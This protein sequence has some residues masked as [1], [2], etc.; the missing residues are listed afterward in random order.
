MDKKSITLGLIVIMAVLFVLGC[1]FENR[2]GYYYDNH[3]FNFVKVEKIKNVNGTV[4]HPFTF[5]E[6]QM[7]TI[8]KLIEVKRG[9][10][11]GSD[12]KMKNVFDDRALNKLVPPLVKAFSEITPKEKLAF[13]F[14]VKDPMFVIKNDRYTTGWMWVEDGKLH[15]EF[16]KLYVKVTGDT[17]KRGYTADKLVQNARGLKTELDLGAG[18]EYGRST[19]ELIID[20]SAFATIAEERRKKQEELAE[21]GYDDATVKI[22]VEREKGVRE[23]L[24]ELD[25]LKK[26]HLITEEEYQQKK[27]ELLDKM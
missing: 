15:V 8:L 10:L 26:E 17:D 1:G 23:K 16:N 13:G 19:G 14:L 25:T 3:W 6:P 27:K 12:E 24:K 2:K 5:T 18:Q 11:F 20:P 9:S 7:S 21:K 22:R 4:T